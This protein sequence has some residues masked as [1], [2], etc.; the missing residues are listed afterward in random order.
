MPNPNTIST[1]RYQDIQIPDESIRKQF[2]QYMMTGRYAEALNLLTTNAQ[3]LQGKAYVADAIN[4]I[5]TGILDL[6]GRY[7]DGV[8]VFLSDLAHQFNTLIK[9]MKRMGLWQNTVQYYPYSYVVYNQ[10]IYLCLT[11]PPIGTLPSDEQYWLY[12]GL[13]GEEGAYGIDVNMKYG[14]SASAQYKINDIVTYNQNIYVALKDNANANPETDATAWMLFILVAKGEINIGMN[15]PTILAQNTIWFKTK[16]DPLVATTVEPIY[17]QFFRYIKDTKQWEEMYPNTVFTLVD[18][19]GQYASM[20]ENIEVV[21]KPTD[22]I[23]DQFA[24]PY[25]GLDKKTTAFIYP[26]LPYDASQSKLYN[27]LKLTVNA[28]DLV[29]A[30]PTSTAIDF[31]LPIV[32]SIQ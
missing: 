12:L 16:S 23:N 21:I 1:Y 3:K 31:N 9:N 13:R 30:K 19:Y 10:E 5:T 7:N 8:P 17:G 22:W 18:G 15:P 4:K 24:Y 25:R 28:N 26:S 29:L 14:W 6:Q 32:I 27:Q 2:K 11:E 20:V